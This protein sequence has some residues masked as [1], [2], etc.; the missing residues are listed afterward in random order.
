MFINNFYL[1]FLVVILEI[2]NNF[3]AIHAKFSSKWI[4]KTPIYDI[5][6]Y[7][8]TL[9][10][11][12]LNTFLSVNVVGHRYIS[13]MRHF[14]ARSKPSEAQRTDTQIKQWAQL[15]LK[16]KPQLPPKARF[17]RLLRLVRTTVEVFFF[18]FTELVFSIR[19]WCS[20][21]VKQMNTLMYLTLN[22]KLSKLQAIPM[23]AQLSDT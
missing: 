20:H 8:R 2:R 16:T 13:I 9:A 17:H 7:I 3:N 11:I 23:P 6:L 5:K 18:L 12:F 22:L 19:E 4:Y 15:I 10:K 21:S 14:F 1:F